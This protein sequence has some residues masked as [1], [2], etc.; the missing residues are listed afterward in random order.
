MWIVYFVSQAQSNGFTLEEAGSFVTIAGI[1]NLFGTI[2]QGLITDRGVMSSWTLVAV[3]LVMS[4]VSYLA[5]S[6]LTSYWAMMTSA[7]LILF[8]EGVLSCQTDVLV[9]Q[10][11]GVELLAGA[12]GWIG[13][14]VTLL[15]VALGFLP[16]LVYD[17]TGSYTAAFLLIGSV[18]AVPLVPLLMLRYSQR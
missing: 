15:L 18:Q 4:S 6:L 13:L 8:I 9:K 7:V 11:L 14:K 16:G 10:V 12:F 2:S 5:S 1:A 3:C 17:L